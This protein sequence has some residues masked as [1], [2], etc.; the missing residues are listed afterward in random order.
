MHFFGPKQVFFRR[1][2]TTKNMEGL[3]R[4]SDVKYHIPSTCLDASKKRFSAGIYSINRIHE[5]PQNG[6]NVHGFQA[7]A[8]ICRHIVPVSRASRHIGPNLALKNKE[9]T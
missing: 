5:T 2:C 1:F 8:P 9:L 3:V 4:D 6:Q 7:T